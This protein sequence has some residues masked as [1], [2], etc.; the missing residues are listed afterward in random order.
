MEREP[1]FKLDLQGL[2]RTGIMLATIIGGYY[3]IISTI[4]DKVADNK[5]EIAIVRAEVERHEKNT[6]VYTMDELSDKFVLR[7]EWESNHKYLREDVKY[8]RDKMDLI[9]NKLAESKKF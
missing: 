3:Q 4:N 6:R 1:K 5:R 2:F 8:I 9:V 7:K